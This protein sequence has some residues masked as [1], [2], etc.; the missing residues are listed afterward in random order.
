MCR[1]NFEFTAAFFPHGSLALMSGLWVWALPPELRLPTY[2]L[3]LCCVVWGTAKPSTA[4]RRHCWICALASPFLFQS[5]LALT[6]WGWAPFSPT[7]SRLC[8]SVPFCAFCGWNVLSSATVPASLDWNYLLPP[9]PLLSPGPVLFALAVSVTWEAF[10]PFFHMTKMLFGNLCTTECTH[11]WP[12][13]AGLIWLPWWLDIWKCSLLGQSAPDWNVHFAV[14]LLNFLLSLA[15]QSPVH[16]PL[17]EGA[18][19]HVRFSIL[20]NEFKTRCS[21]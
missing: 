3:C 19:K 11:L 14:S 20:F 5:S 17:G 2:H 16:S 18:S 9:L 8:L 13:S 15:S 12:S 6:C 4:C 21:M 7:S 10:L 1:L